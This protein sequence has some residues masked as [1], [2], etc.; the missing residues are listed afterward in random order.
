MIEL[1]FDASILKRRFDDLGSRQ[2][3]FAIA[4]T[5]TRVGYVIQGA[6][7]AEIGAAF[8]RPT[9]YTMK[10]VV[11]LKATKKNL[12]VVILVKDEAPKGTPPVKYLAPGV[13]GGSRRV[14]RFERALRAAGILGPNELA[15]PARGAKLN[16]YGNISS[17]T[18]TS[19][20]SVLKASPDPMQNITEASKKR[21]KR[22]RAFFVRPEAKRGKL[23]RGVWERRGAAGKARLV[24][25]FV[26]ENDV[27]Y[28]K[29]YKFFTVVDQVLRRGEM[30]KQFKIAM[31]EARR[32]ARR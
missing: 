15:V 11:V 16:A 22:P 23:P 26:Q 14:K 8:D 30:R 13:Y 28:E 3:P 6:E 18:Y 19:I 1:K 4:L 2:L 5:L 12:S 10:S 21:N 20:L 31:R 32:T 17:G 7:S 25:L 24:L 9:P 29:R 27:S